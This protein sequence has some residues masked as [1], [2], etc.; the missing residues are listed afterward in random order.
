LY[1]KWKSYVLTWSFAKTPGHERWYVNGVKLSFNTS[2]KPF[3]NIRRPGSLE[4]K[5]AKSTMLFPTPVGKSYSCPSQASV[6]L[7]DGDVKATVFLQVFKLQPFMSKTDFGP[8]YECSPGGG[9]AFRD[10][11]APIAVGSTLAVVVLLTVTG[12][13]VYRYVKIKKVQYDTME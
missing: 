4:L 3:Q 6:E 5:T 10:E 2:E 8:E 1:L 11:T 7:R 12:Y 9:L 13:G